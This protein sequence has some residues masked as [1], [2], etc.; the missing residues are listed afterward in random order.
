MSGQVV[1]FA[2]ANHWGCVGA[3][4]FIA[5]GYDNGYQFTGWGGPAWRY[6]EVTLFNF[7]IQIQ[8][9]TGRRL[10]RHE[11]FDVPIGI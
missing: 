10:P 3:H 2:L 1:R 6:F 11:D 8:W 4:H 9:R 5:L 7:G